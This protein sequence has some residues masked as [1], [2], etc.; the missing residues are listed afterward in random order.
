MMSND[1]QP[2]GALRSQF[3]LSPA[4]RLML[5]SDGSVTVRSLKEMMVCETD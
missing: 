1:Q 5:L 3:L 4:W 2:G